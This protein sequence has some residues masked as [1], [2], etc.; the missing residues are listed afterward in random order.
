[1]AAATGNNPRLGAVTEAAS[2]GG[3]GGAVSSKHKRA[4]AAAGDKAFRE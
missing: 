1:M 2:S 3:A 4:T